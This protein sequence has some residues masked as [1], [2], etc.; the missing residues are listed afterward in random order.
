MKSKVMR[1]TT[2]SF[3]RYK[4][5]TLPEIIVRDLDWF[6]WALRTASSRTRRKSVRGGY[7][8]SKF[9]NRIRASWRSNIGMKWTADL[10]AFRS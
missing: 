10:V 6:F 3:G 4:G 7:G 9:Q 5:K 8:R 2:V 1:W